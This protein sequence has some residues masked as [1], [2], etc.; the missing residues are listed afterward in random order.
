MRILNLLEEHTRESL[1]VY[2]E[3]RWSIAKVIHTLADVMVLKSVPTGSGITYSA[4]SVSLMRA[5][6]LGRRRPQD[7]R[8]PMEYGQDKQTVRSDPK[9]V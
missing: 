2:Q 6:A 8:L 7:P 1:L 4:K 9:A 3:P 5:A